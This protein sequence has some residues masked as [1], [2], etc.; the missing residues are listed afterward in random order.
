M[1]AQKP[2][3]GG[4]DLIG[5]VRLFDQP[6][7][8]DTAKRPVGGVPS[9]RVNDGDV[10]ITLT[11]DRR[12]LPPRRARPKADV[13]D[14]AGYSQAGIV[15]KLDRRRPIHRLLHLVAASLQRFLG[16]K[17]NEV[18][19][20]YQQEDDLW[21][22]CSYLT[23]VRACPRRHGST[24]VGKFDQFGR[25]RQSLAGMMLKACIKGRL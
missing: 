20:F 16:G 25:T 7:L 2:G 6:A 22:V 19:V 14:E 13:G 9:G 23:K 1:A 4:Y 15:Q 24:G 11:G 17:Q 12:Y 5:P 10:R 3:Y 21:N 8:L 18:V